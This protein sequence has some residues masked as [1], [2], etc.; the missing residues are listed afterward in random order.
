MMNLTFGA[1]FWTR[2]AGAA[3]LLVALEAPAAAQAVGVRAGVSV[4]PEQFYFGGHV[5]T[6]PLV[7]R[8]HFRPN[9]EIGVGDDAT[10]AAFNVE[11]AYLCPSQEAWSLYAGA[12]PA[13]NIIDSGGDAEA[14]PGFNFLIGVAHE[15]GLF[16][17]FKVG[18][19]DSPRLKFGVGYAFRW[20]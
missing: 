18:A 20:R 7:D 8:L 14:E 15:G 16:A 17:E 2:L 4:D 9:V 13:L 19:F 12:G 1:A 11:F 6:P 10:L 5:Q 3:I